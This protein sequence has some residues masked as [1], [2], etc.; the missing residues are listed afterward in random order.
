MAKLINSSTYIPL[1]TTVLAGKITLGGVSFLVGRGRS[2]GSLLDSLG[3]LRNMLE[4]TRILRGLELIFATWSRFQKAS[5]TSTITSV[6][7]F[8]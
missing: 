4:S 6:K 3:D 1:V 5:F 7:L 2:S 8:M